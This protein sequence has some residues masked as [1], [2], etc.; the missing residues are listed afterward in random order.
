MKRCD[1]CGQSSG[2]VQCPDCGS[3]SFGSKP[4]SQI[5]KGEPFHYN[6]YVV[7]W[8][9]TDWAYDKAEYLFYLGDRLVE[10]FTISRDV[11]RMFVPEYQ[12]SMPFIWD[13][14]LIAQGEEE[15]LRVVEQ[16]TTKPRTFRITLDPSPE[17]EYALGLS[18]SVMHEAI[19]AG[20][21]RLV[22][23]S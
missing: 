5:T 2:E 20:Q 17:K 10:R 11:L 19:A 15:V 22:C 14:F 7:W 3:R 9:A 1:Y 6:G 23:S 13:L 12:S 18:I 16:N 4:V 21:R 8:L